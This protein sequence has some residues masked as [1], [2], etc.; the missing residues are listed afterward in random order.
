[1]CRHS[2]KD[3]HAYTTQICVVNLSE[4]WIDEN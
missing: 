3:S 2:E 1:M 4:L